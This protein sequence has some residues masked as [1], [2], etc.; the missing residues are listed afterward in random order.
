MFQPLAQFD[1]QTQKKII[2]AFRLQTLLVIVA[3]LA[4]SDSGLLLNS[5]NTRI[6]ALYLLSNVLLVAVPSR[7]FNSS[8]VTAAMLIADVV[9]VSA[10]IYVSGNAGGDLYLLYFLAI[11]MAALS[12]DL[13][14]TVIAAMVVSAVYMW[15]SSTSSGGPEILSSEFLLRI[16]LF[17]VTAFFAGFLANQARQRESEQR[18]TKQVAKELERELES[19]RQHEQKVLGEYDDLLFHHQNIMSSIHSGICVIDTDGVVTIFN[20]EAERITGLSAQEVRGQPVA[21]FLVLKPLAAFLSKACSL[22][23]LISSRE[24][25][26]IPEDGRVIE[27]GFSTSPLRDQHK[28]ITGAIVTFRDL[29]EIRRLR[30]QVQRSEQMAFLGQ[31]TAALASQILEPLQ[32]INTFAK[33]QC[34][35]TTPSDQFHQ[36]AEVIVKETN[37]IDSILSQTM[38]FTGGRVAHEPIDLNDVIRRALT[39]LQ[40]K[41]EGRSISITLDLDPDLPLV[42]GSVLQ[43]Q[44]A[45]SHL[46]VNALEAINEKGGLRINTHARENEVVSCFADNGPGIPPELWDRVFDPFFTTKTQ[47]L[48]L[49]LAVAQKIAADHGGIITLVESSKKGTVFE[50][51]LPAHSPATD[52]LENLVLTGCRQSG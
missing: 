16:P 47:G 32:S 8:T 42:I 19:T 21:R 29:V 40:D 11:F 50:I 20:R 17:F 4:F 6:V 25:V 9:F 14:T 15:V 22:G 38:V 26:L 35:K 23:R 18:K 45:C 10:C 48:G 5:W 33:L 28:R 44:R 46:I 51:G 2:L 37:K 41:L 12:R 3:L 36:F 43:L 1:T 27:I 49:G 34:S 30:D 39:G 24:T 31:M 13:R 7:F 52:G